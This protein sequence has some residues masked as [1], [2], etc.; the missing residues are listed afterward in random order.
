MR[1]NRCKKSTSLAHRENP[2]NGIYEIFYSHSSM[3][4]ICRTCLTPKYPNYARTRVTAS[5]G[6]EAR[7]FSTFTFFHR[8]NKLR[9]LIQ[10]HS[11][12]KSEI[13]Y[14]LSGYRA[15]TVI[16]KL[17]RLHA[18]T[19]PQK[20]AYPPLYGSIIFT[21]M[22]ENSAGM[23]KLPWRKLFAE[24]VRWLKRRMYKST[25]PNEKYTQEKL[26]KTYKKHNIKKYGGK[27]KPKLC[28]DMWIWKAISY[29]F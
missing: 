12:L 3:R 11:N 16:R 14:N 8:A 5:K 24:L 21:H 1:Q 22:E 9:F 10:R 28:S 29:P 15:R 2:R 6:I 20:A 26:K 27:R 7:D 4:Q 13:K 18:H 25:L 17:T 19:P 23:V